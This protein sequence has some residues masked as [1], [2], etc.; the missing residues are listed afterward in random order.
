MF[1]E[2]HSR[3][4]LVVTKKNIKKVKEI[5]SKKKN[6]FDVLGSFTSDQICIKHKSQNLVKVNVDTA[7]RKYINALKEI[8]DDG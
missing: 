5:L 3:Y 2:S 4:L 7:Q 6:L 8:L 1:S